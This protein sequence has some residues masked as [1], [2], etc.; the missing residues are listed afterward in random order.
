MY[1]GTARDSEPRGCDRDGGAIGEASPKGFL[2]LDEL[3]RR[4]LAPP[5]E[6]LVS[7]QPGFTDSSEQRLRTILAK[8]MS[9]VAQL[10]R[11]V[12]LPSAA[13]AEP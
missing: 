10:L 8:S 1:S 4:L 11:N 13:S 2:P 5:A 12:Y 7:E 9:K 6:P 3:R